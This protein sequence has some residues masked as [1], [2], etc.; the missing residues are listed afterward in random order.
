MVLA[1]SSALTATA[2]SPATTA[3]TTAAAADTAANTTADATAGA[4]VV[5]EALRLDQSQAEAGTTVSVV[6]QADI[7][8]RALTVAGDAV[9]MVPGVTVTQ[10]G[11]FGGVAYARIRGNASGQTLVLIDGVPVNDPS[12]P[13]GGFD[14]S[15]YDLADV[16][17][18]EVLHGPQSTLWGSDAVGGVIAILT[19]RPG[20]GVGWAGFAEAGSFDTYRAGASVSGGADR[21]D[22]RL[23]A[24]WQTSDGISKADARDGNTEADGFRSFSLSGRG[25]VSLA[26]SLRLDLTARW[27]KA[28]YA[29]D[30]FPP[31]TY[32]LADTDEATRSDERAGSATLT[33]PAFGGRLENSLQVTRMEID[34]RNYDA[35]LQTSRNKGGQTGYRYNAALKVAAGHRLAFGVEREES[36]ANGAAAETNAAFALYEWSPTGRLTLT[37]GVRYDDDDRYGSATTGK[38]AASWRAAD[39]LRFRA[40]WGQG[41]AAPTIFQS[42]YICAFCGLTAPNPDL[43][44]ATSDAYDAGVD[45]TVGKADVSVTA[46]TQRT[47][48]L[49]DFSNAAGY[50]NIALAKQKG[51]EASVRAP[52]AGWLAV[53]V[54]YAYIDGEDGSGADLPRVPLNSG[55][56]ELILTPTAK[57]TGSIAVRYND[58]Q[59]D[60]FGPRVKGWTRTDLSAAYEFMPGLEVYG[61]I[62]NLFDIHYQQIGGYGTPGLSGLVGLRARK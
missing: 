25:G 54:G 46:F 2:Q 1:G 49:I 27:T 34:R 55:N 41:F 6:S 15:T 5:V 12:S 37:G 43:K 39:R 61:R 8:R 47:T 40:T 33:A 45:W 3:A 10:S 51:V 24:V 26:D 28:D 52:V 56:L 36:S 60:G 57:V 20:K 19:K 32:A 62:E 9:A 44:A 16:A 59:S 11:S 58:D 22:G 35:G 13:S 14:L 7:Q 50:A 30:G 4:T 21:A 23:S 31:P 18:V 38:V 17:R 53:Q 48:N 29:F 42:T